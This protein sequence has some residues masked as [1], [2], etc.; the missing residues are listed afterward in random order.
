MGM[1]DRVEVNLNGRIVETDPHMALWLSET[2]PDPEGPFFHS[3]SYGD[4]GCVDPETGKPGVIVDVDPQ[5]GSLLVCDNC[6]AEF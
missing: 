3:P 6:G 2:A 1:N 5:G 4:K